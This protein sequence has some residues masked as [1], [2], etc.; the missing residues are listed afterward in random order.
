MPL[1]F[2][3]DP[4]RLAQPP[5]PVAHLL[6]IAHTEEDMRFRVVDAVFDDAVILRIKPCGN[7]VVIGKSFAGE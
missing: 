6:P 1:L 3:S 2:G 5:A 7:G 4:D